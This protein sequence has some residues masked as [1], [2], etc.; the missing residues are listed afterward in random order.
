MQPVPHALL[1]GANRAQ[2][3]GEAPEA[4]CDVLVEVRP[5][6]EG[7]VRFFLVNAVSGR[8]LNKPDTVLYAISLTLRLQGKLLTRFC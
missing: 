1:R 8:L 4:K 5:H 7:I 3:V 6:R 2:T